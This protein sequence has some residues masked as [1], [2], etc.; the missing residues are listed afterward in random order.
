MR[1]PHEGRGGGAWGQL[2]H[3]HIPQQ[4]KHELVVVV[5]RLDAQLLDF[6]THYHRFRLS[7]MRFPHRS[8]NSVLFVAVYQE[9][10]ECGD[11]RSRIR[12]GGTS[13]SK[14][15]HHELTWRYDGGQ[16]FATMGYCVRRRVAIRRKLQKISKVCKPL[17]KGDVPDVRY[18][19]S[20]S[21]DAGSLAAS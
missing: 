15:H 14:L 19:Y 4:C 2:D 6:D 17:G 8:G 10:L 18:H 20:R 9:Q 21:V 16:L 5:N 3:R 7:L 1:S 13:S 12:L 11:H